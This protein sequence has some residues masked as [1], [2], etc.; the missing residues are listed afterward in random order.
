MSSP[1]RRALLLGLG[2]A[3]LLAGCGFRPALKAGTDQRG[4]RGTVMLSVPEGRL[5][6]AMR[7]TLE[8]R[9]GRPGDAPT[10]LLTA[11]LR[12]DD[13]GLA[14]TPDSSIT[15][16]VIRASSRWSLTGPEGFR[17]IEDVSESMTAYSATASLFATR[18]AR[19][20]AETRA[21]TEIG[22]RIWTRIL[23]ELEARAA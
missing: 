22:E 16:Y 8:R 14:I 9:F 17:P 11:D 21:A 19:R 2:A 18:Q 4:L 1:D 13:T 23:A 7:E 15:R 10:H 20:D 3:G 12:I 6:F 5:G